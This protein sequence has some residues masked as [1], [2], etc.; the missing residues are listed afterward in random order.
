MNFHALGANCEQF[1]VAGAVHVDAEWPTDWL[2][3]V[4]CGRSLDSRRNEFV[5]HATAALRQALAM[6]PM[7]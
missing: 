5:R 2:A 7:V 1:K 3:Q 6:P 4:V